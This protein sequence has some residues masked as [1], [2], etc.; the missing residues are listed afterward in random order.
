MKR[1]SAV[2]GRFCLAVNGKGLWRDERRN[3]DERGQ[4]REILEIPEDGN[5]RREPANQQQLE[6]ESR[7]A[8]EDQSYDAAPLRTHLACSFTDA[9]TAST[10]IETWHA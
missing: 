1:I 3:H 2:A 7:Q 6:K 9:K 4:Q 5:L 10:E 8:P